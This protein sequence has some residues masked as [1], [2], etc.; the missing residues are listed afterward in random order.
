MIINFYLTE[1]WHKNNIP[2]VNTDHLQI[3]STVYFL[4]EYIISF[5]VHIFEQKLSNIITQI[6]IMMRTFFLYK[7]INCFLTFYRKILLYN[8]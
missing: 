8:S 2:M 7:T 1:I 6:P 5:I 4:G 3:F